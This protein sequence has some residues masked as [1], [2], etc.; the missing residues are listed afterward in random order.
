MRDKLIELL[1][2]TPGIGWSPSARK[3]V[4]DHLISNSVTFAT[5]TNVGSKWIPVS[6]RLPDERV[7]V[8]TFTDKGTQR[9]GRLYGSEWYT[10]MWELDGVT[11]W[12]P[13]PDPPK[14]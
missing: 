5:D 13:L 14:V 11:H 7:P 10:T 12:M 4:A 9:I 8:L 3:A 1:G 2:K 6:E